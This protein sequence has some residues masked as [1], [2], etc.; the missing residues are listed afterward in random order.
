[1]WIR[2]GKEEKMKRNIIALSAHILLLG[3]VVA[4]FGVSS[5]IRD[6]ADEG[7]EKFTGELERN[8][9]LRI[10]ENDTAKETG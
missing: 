2:R 8:V 4:G 10:L 9:T 3:G 1:M 7:Q 5:M 6:D